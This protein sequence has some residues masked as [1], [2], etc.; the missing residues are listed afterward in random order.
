V[1]AVGSR[2][3][4]SSSP[5]SLT[6]VTLKKALGAVVAEVRPMSPAAQADMRVGDIVTIF[7]GEN[8]RRTRD[9][10]R[11]IAET[12]PGKDVRVTVVRAGLPGSHRDAY[13]AA[14]RLKSPY[15]VTSGKASRRATSVFVSRVAR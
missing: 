4:V 6:G 10:Q 12:P 13:V 11:L 8:V 7:D 5:R 9:L 3:D 15:A 2:C 14:T 1:A